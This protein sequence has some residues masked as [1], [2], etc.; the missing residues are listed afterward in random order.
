M[1]SW[2]YSYEPGSPKFHPAIC[3]LD[4]LIKIT[5]EGLGIYTHVIT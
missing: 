4:S 2:Y 3:N 1:N 5:I